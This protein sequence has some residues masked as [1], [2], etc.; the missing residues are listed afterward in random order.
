M[1]KGYI[2]EAANEVSKPQGTFQILVSKI[3]D[4]KREICKYLLL[5]KNKEDAA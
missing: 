3:D 5:N 2:K 4:I 1:Y